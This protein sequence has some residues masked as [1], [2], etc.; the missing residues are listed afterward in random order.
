MVF[1]FP[2]TDAMQLVLVPT[3]DYTEAIIAFETPE[4]QSMDCYEL[5]SWLKNLEKDQPFEMTHL[6]PDLFRA[7]FTT[8]I[9]EPLEL[10][11][12][13]EKICG[14]VINGPLE[15]FANHMA[16]SRELYLWWD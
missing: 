13:I 16:T 3:T 4:G 5:V 12:R 9:K 6:A 15:K 1:L 2:D 14:D 10:A 7:R 11:K 8:E